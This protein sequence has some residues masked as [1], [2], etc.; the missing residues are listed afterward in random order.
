[1]LAAAAECCAIA[2]LDRLGLGAPMAEL[3]ENIV[4]MTALR[5][6]IFAIN[7]HARLQ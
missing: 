5:K 1:M 4:I 2:I 7:Y 3:T 6:T